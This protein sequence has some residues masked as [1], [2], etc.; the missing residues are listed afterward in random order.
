MVATANGHGS[1][2]DDTDVVSMTVTTSPRRP[3]FLQQVRWDAVQKT[4]LEGMSIRKMARELGL[5]RDTVRRYIDAGS[6]P[7]RRQAYR[8]GHLIRSP[9]R[10]GT[11]SLNVD[12]RKPTIDPPTWPTLPPPFTVRPPHDV[13]T[14]IYWNLAWPVRLP[15]PIIPCVNANA[16]PFGGFGLRLFQ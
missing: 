9:N 3:T 6:P 7:M 13:L 8:H 5:H 1:V 15:L 12:S 14:P 2:I 16:H 10:R 11:F 4:K